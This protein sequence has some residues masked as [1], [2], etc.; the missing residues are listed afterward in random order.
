MKKILL[1]LLVMT[2]PL[3]MGNSSSSSSSSSS[4][5]AKYVKYFNKGQA[6]QDKKD[7]EQAV[8]WYEKALRDKPDHADSWNNLGFSLRMI[9]KGYLD[10]AGKAYQKA[11]TVDAD[12]DEALEYQGELYLWWGKLTEADQ[13]LQRLKKMNSPEAKELGQKLEH[14]LAQAKKLI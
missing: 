8:S 4:S 7:Y 13:N 2:A 10:E 3:L 5:T 11:L 6:A 12:H 9:G 1:V 14:I